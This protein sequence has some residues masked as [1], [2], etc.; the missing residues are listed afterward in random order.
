MKMKAINYLVAMFILIMSSFCGLAQNYIIDEITTLDS[1]NSN[2]RYGRQSLVRDN[3]GTIHFFYIQDGNTADYLIMR[4][5]V[6]DGNT[7]SDSDTISI[8][9]PASSA[10]RYLAV[11]PSATVDEQN[12]LHI[13]YE[14][15]G[16]PIYSSSWSAYPPSHMNYVTNKTGSWVTDV[17]V[18]NDSEIQTSQG[19]GETVSYLSNNQI[20]NYNEH[21]HY[22]GYD[23]AWWATKYNIVYSNNIAG[24][25]LPGSA[26]HTFDLGTY[27]NVMLNAPSMVVNN[28][29]LFSLW[30]QRQ[31]CRVEMKSF[32]VED[33]SPLNVLYNDV[34]FPTPA[35][36]WRS[37]FSTS[38]W[39]SLRPR[40]WP[41]SFRCC[42]PAASP[43]CSCMSSR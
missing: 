38:S 17:N 35:P 36:T 37:G 32:L 41:C 30:Y 29:S 18:I 25:W 9:T 19:N 3:M 43:A 23:Y 6:D 15:R 5:S 40:W 26:L 14:Y 13:L 7:W 42:S 24:N 21:K 28:D 4:S 20:I 22:I 27:D 16:L 11:A 8:H 39:P 10:I 1:S 34:V 12:F 31:D 33:W 2:I